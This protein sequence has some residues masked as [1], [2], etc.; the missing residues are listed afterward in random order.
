MRYIF[1]FPKKVYFQPCPCCLEYGPKS[2]VKYLSASK[3]N[4]Y[5]LSS[6]GTV[7]RP[8]NSPDVLYADGQAVLIVG[9][10]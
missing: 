8:T 1:L 10:A 3:R 6:I 4:I 9:F 7:I 2:G 5:V